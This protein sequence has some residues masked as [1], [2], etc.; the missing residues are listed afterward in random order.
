M[1]LKAYGIPPWQV[2]GSSMV[3]EFQ[4]K[5]GKSDVERISKIDI[6]DDK[7]CKPVGIYEHIGVRPIF[8]FGNS[9]ADIAMMQY[10]MGG[11]GRRMGLF[12]HH[13]DAEREYTYDRKS[14]VGRMDIALDEAEENGWII[15]DM[16]N[17][18]N[19]IFPEK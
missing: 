4:V 2:V 18:W 11:K 14:N 13:T 3:S 16:K 19:K 8:A 6:V 17:D 15:V 10:T 9:D 7:E 1:T 5:D 12:V